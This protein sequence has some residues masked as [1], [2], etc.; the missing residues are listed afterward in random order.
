MEV[1]TYLKDILSRFPLPIAIAFNQKFVFINPSFRKLTGFSIKSLSNFSVKEFFSKVPRLVK[2]FF[3][4]IP[5][6]YNKKLFTKVYLIRTKINSYRVQIF[7]FIDKTAERFLERNL[8]LIAHVLMLTLSSHTQEELLVNLVKTLVVDF[9]IDCA[10]I[11]LV[12]KKGK[13]FLWFELGSPPGFIDKLDLNTITNCKDNILVIKR[14]S[15]ANILKTWQPVLQSYGFESLFVLP[16]LEDD[17]VIGYLVG[18]SKKAEFFDEEFTNILY[19]MQYTLKFSFRRFQTLRENFILNT[20]IEKG[21][22]WVGILDEEKKFVYVNTFACELMGWTKE[23][24]L[25][26]G[27]EVFQKD[28]KNSLSFEEM[29]SAMEKGENYTGIFVIQ[30]EKEEKIYLYLQMI[31]VI[32]PCKVERY[33]LIGRDVSLELDLLSMIETLKTKDELTGLYN[34]TGILEEAEKILNI[35]DLGVAFCLL[36]IRKIDWILALYG[37]SIRDELI[38]KIAEFL[39]EKFPGALIARISEDTFLLVFLFLRNKVE[40]YHLINIIL[41]RFKEPI[42]VSRFS[43]SPSI[44]LGVSFYPEDGTTA[45]ELY[46]KAYIAL[47]Q[48]K[49]EGPNKFYFYSKEMEQAIKKILNAEELIKT[50]IEN[51][52]FTFF[53]QPY[54]SSKEE[55]IKGGETLVRIDKDGEVIPPKFFIEELE[56]SEYLKDFE[57]W[58]LV[59]V[60]NLSKEMDLPLSINLTPERFYDIEFWKKHRKLLSELKHPLILEITER[61]IL[62]DLKRAQYIVEA[63]KEEFP[64]IK[65]AIDDFGTGQTNFNYLANLKIDLIKID[66]EYTQKM[67]LNRKILAIVDSIIYLAKK[68]GVE[69]LAEGVETEAQVYTLKEMGCDY[70]QGFYFS[71]PLPRD[72]FKKF[73]ETYKSRSFRA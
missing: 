55:V 33:V 11:T 15:E 72:E 42:K 16:I 5:N 17:K 44:N 6:K 53:I 73:L 65:I 23:E 41:E 66:M 43:L 70:L 68:L 18:L 64:G 7:I 35:A 49:A 45:N 14:S 56:S 32:L 39:K 9:E 10:F 19:E 4:E 2:S 59:E 26:H 28:P 1:P 57:E 30:G 27:I 25:N 48:A 62:K 12:S 13:P 20:A 22:F 61:G 31:P 58:A 34:L 51:K 38:V 54:F 60:V 21:E 29:K 63:L 24:A 40:V 36:F 69:T 50:A 71:K 47:K 8:S 37:S 52:Q 3:C 67:L 46:Y